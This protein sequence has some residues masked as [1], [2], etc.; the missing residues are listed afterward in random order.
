MIGKETKC[1][2]IT[3]SVLYFLAP[4]PAGLRQLAWGMSTN[5]VLMLLR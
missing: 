3:L 1:F 5:M 4:L 2:S